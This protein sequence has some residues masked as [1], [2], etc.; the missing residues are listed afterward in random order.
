VTLS[1]RTSIVRRTPLLAALLI[2]LVAL[3]APA[4]AQAQACANVNLKP[5]RANLEIVR[6]AV[7]CLH[8]AERARNGL[9]RLTENP[10]LRRAAARH[11]AHMAAARFF[12]HTTPAGATMV[13]RIRRTGYT[14]GARGWTVGENIAWG[15]GRLAT[16]AQIH[17][18]WMNS[19]GHRANIL[20]RSFREIGI[21]IETGVPV[22]VSAA[23]FGATY[24]A[25][26][27]ARR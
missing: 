5:T 7:L 20:Q 23:Q 22:R 27:G 26:F 21:G 19:P 4:A 2:A 9:P 10:R 11:T 16:A 18:S 13:D 8:N 24:T 1:F 3:L 14:S 6:S 25:D 15:T 12:D 17:R